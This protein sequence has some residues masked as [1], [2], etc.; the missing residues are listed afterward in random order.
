MPRRALSTIAKQEHARRTLMSGFRRGQ[1]LG[2]TIIEKS[3]TAEKQDPELASK[4][5]SKKKSKGKER[6]KS[7]ESRDKSQ[8]KVKREKDK[9]RSKDQRKKGK[10]RSKDKH[11]KDKSE[12]KDKRQSKKNSKSKDKSQSKDKSGNIFP[13]KLTP[14]DTP[15]RKRDESSG[16]PQ[17]KQR[18]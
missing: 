13:D 17:K 3:S 8:P 18:A 10:G 11:E 2:G 14:Q 7:S 1:V 4:E 16:G 6:S 15:K 12:S 9:D 5:K